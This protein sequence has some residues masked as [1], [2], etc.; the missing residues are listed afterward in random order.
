MLKI[1]TTLDDYEPWAGAIETFNT[2]KNNNMLD[3]FD[4]LMEDFYPEG[5]TQTQLN[6]IL[7]FDSE[8][9]LEQLGLN[10]NESEEE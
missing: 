4:F 10:D 1:I 6:D 7:R 2:I 8:W 5:I 3:D 9:I